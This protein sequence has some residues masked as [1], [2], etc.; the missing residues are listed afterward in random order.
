MKLGDLDD[1]GE[2]KLIIADMNKKIKIYKG[3]NVFYEANLTDM[4]VGVDIIYSTTKK[5][6]INGCYFCANILICSD[7]IYRSG[8]WLRSVHLPQIQAVLQIQTSFP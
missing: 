3:T 6:S 8:M 5:P 2:H 7:S 1:D 4:P